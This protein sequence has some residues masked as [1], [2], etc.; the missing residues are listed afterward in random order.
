VETVFQE[1][2]AVARRQNARF[3][4]LRAAVS[5]AHLWQDQGKRRE[6]RDL[7][8]EVYRRFTEG[9]GTAD[10]AEANAILQEMRE[11]QGKS[12]AQGWAGQAGN[13]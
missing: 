12:A 1:A 5:T 8:L 11:V 9:F 3:L 13:G 2:L 7:L 10:L 4:E 6:A